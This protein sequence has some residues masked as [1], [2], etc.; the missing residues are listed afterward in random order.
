MVEV[1]LGLGVLF[2][3][4]T[5]ISRQ[6]LIVCS[7]GLVALIRIPFLIPLRTNLRDG[8]ALTAVKVLSL[9]EPALGLIAASLVTLRPLLRALQEGTLRPDKNVLETYKN[10]SPHIRPTLWNEDS[11]MQLRKDVGDGGLMN[12]VTNNNRPSDSDEQDNDLELGVIRVERAINFDSCGSLTSHELVSLG[13]RTS[14]L[15]QNVT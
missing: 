10:I 9:T 7:A 6:K 4:P 8:R 12:V 15:S 3:C 1:L 13:I 14:I 2:V 5:N 11:T